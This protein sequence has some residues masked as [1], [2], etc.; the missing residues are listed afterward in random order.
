MDKSKELNRL[1]RRMSRTKELQ[2]E[3]DHR[4]EVE[5]KVFRLF[6]EGKFEEGKALLDT[7]DNKKVLEL[8]EGDATAEEE[9]HITTRD[10]TCVVMHLQGLL[11]ETRLGRN[12]VTGT[13]LPCWMCPY[14]GR[15][16]P[17]G[18]DEFKYMNKV[19]ELKT[20]VTRCAEYHINS[21]I[22]NSLMSRKM[23]RENACDNC[24]NKWCNHA[25]CMNK[26][27]KPLFALYNKLNI[28]CYGYLSKSDI[29]CLK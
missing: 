10:I 29:Q 18:F 14:L 19:F 20:D 13:L 24:Q 11:Y 3:L 1:D 22:N 28:R 25:T 7:L 17:Q 12:S 4:T 16:M 9:S 8:A 23:R 5:E 27:L 26:T 15:C 6:S 2:A 21:Y